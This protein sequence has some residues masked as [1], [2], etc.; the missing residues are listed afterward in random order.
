MPEIKAT[1]SRAVDIVMDAVQSPASASSGRRVEIDLRSLKAALKAK[2]PA[3]AR[4]Y[5]AGI[6]KTGDAP[7]G[8]S[9]PAAVSEALSS[10]VD[11]LPDRAVA[12]DPVASNARRIGGPLGMPMGVISRAQQRE[13]ET[14]GLSQALLNR[15]TATMAAAS[16][17]L[18]AGLGA[19]GGSGALSRLS[20]AGRYLLLPSVI[21]LGVGVVLAIP[22]GLILQNVLPH[23][24]Q[25][26]V[27]GSA[28]AQLRA[29]LASV[30]GPI[31][32]SF[33]ITGL[34]GASLGGVLSQARRMGEPKELE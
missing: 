15:M 5:V 6:A 24:L 11:S 29:Y 31:A 28:G 23:G 17:L 4:D 27:G 14:R 20:R 33:F 21:V 13:M 30:L 34:V 12:P 9:Q 22:G 18:L 16:A 8:L 10:A 2:S 3:V 25:G 1:A 26:M 32:R 19:L 7:G